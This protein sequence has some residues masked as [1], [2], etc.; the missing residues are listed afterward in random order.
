M[1]VVADAVQTFSTP[2]IDFVFARW[3]RQCIPFYLKSFPPGLTQTSARILAAGGRWHGYDKSA[4][5]TRQ[6]RTQ[7]L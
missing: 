3:C 6:L 1:N 2:E 5:T 4:E 7:K